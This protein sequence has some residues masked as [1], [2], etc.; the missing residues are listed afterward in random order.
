MSIF[1]VA[2]VLITLTAILAWVN[3]RFVKLPT[4]IG[5]TLGGLLA[6]LAVIGLGEIG[7]GAESWA[8]TL[9]AAVDFD[10]LLMRGMLSFLL[11]AGALHVDL[12]E[13][14]GQKWTVLLLAT[15]GV[16]LSTVVVGGATWWLLGALG[17]PIPFLWALLFGALISPTDPIAVLSILQ[18]AGAPPQVRSLITGES[19][20][21]DGVGVVVFTVLL[22]LVAGGA[23]HGGEITLLGAGT[24]LVQEAVG[25]ALLGLGL[26]YV[27]Y[28]ML[29]AVDDYAVEVLITL[30]LVQGGYALAGVLHTSGPLAMVIA[31]L[32]IGNHGRLLAMSDRTRERLDGFWEMVDE[33]LNAVLF[34]I[35]GLEVLVLTFTPGLLLAGLCAIPLVLLARLLVV[36]VT[37]SG[38]RLRRDLPPWT[39]RLM[40]WGGLRGGISV[41]L[42]LALPAGPE[43]QTVLAITYVVVVFSIVVQGLSVSRV[44]ARVGAEGGGAAVA[45]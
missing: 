32:F 14:L 44:A 26:G 5:V 29:R 42:A 24:L 43:R 28:S 16:A 25:G 41:A 15:L 37:L 19:L 21:N 40:T 10:E 36:G 4:V 45:G 27:A 12:D 23:G 35:I 20:F 38:V 13:L 9:V 11:F 8:E 3:E 7:A 22:G 33:I 18:Q 34:L 2:A 30:A 6:S 1:A 17:L 39:V 31:G